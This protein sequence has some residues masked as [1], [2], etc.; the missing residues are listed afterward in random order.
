MLLVAIIGTSKVHHKKTRKALRLACVIVTAVHFVLSIFGD[1]SVER[2]ID[3]TLPMLMTGPIILE[4]VFTLVLVPL[5]YLG[6]LIQLRGL[7]FDGFGE[8]NRDFESEFKYRLIVILSFCFVGMMFSKYKHEKLIKIDYI[9][10]LRIIEELENS[11]EKI[12]LLM[13]EFVIE[14]MKSFEMTGIL[15][16]NL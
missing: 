9:Q 15:I 4:Y 5:W 12:S 2:F 1:N 3:F 14:R 11:N 7:F 16:F 8:F 6:I 10:K 13:P